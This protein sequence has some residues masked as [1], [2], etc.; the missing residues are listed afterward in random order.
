MKINNKK[1]L[2]VLAAVALVGGTFT[3]VALTKENGFSVS[4]A[5][6]ENTIW[7]HYAA[8]APDPDKKQFGSKEFWANC[9][10][11]GTHV[12]EKPTIGKIQE[13][14]DFSKTAYFKELTP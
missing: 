11:I 5:E 14:D 2:L 6:D 12:F 7:K 1:T 3:A 4:A 8:V 13:G 9:S 10:E